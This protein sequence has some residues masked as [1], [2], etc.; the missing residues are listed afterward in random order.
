MEELKAKI[1]QQK[2]RKTME[3][4][5]FIQELNMKR[6]EFSEAEKK[7]NEQKL[8]HEA[9][10]R[11][12]IDFLSELELGNAPPMEYIVKNL[13]I[14]EKQ[15]N[16]RVPFSV[17][18]IVETTKNNLGIDEDKIK[19]LREAKEETDKLLD[20]IEIKQKPIFI[21]EKTQQV[22]DYI[23][24]LVIDKAW[25]EISIYDQ[26]VDGLKRRAKLM[27][28]RE[29]V[30]DARIG[31]YSDRIAMKQ[32]NNE[33]INRVVFKMLKDIWIGKIKY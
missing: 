19:R 23:I 7:I 29:P 31:F 2:E 11:R 18:E 12:G 15:I 1:L 22:L 16:R 33:L 26:Y 14:E 32:I 24:D 9:I 3:N 30:Q 21:P 8:L 10:T 6:M 13:N 5:Q 28:S 20:K 25:S 17:K 27:K 4:Q